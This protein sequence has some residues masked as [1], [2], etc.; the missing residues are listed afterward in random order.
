MVTLNEMSSLVNFR[1][2][3]KGNS[4]FAEWRNDTYCSLYS[5]YS[6][7]YHFPMYIFDAEASVVDELGNVTGK[8]VWLGNSDKY[9][10]TTTRHQNKCRPNTST[11]NNPMNNPMK[12]LTTEQMR[13]V[14]TAGGYTRYLIMRGEPLAA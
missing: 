12:Y 7:G 11:M 6:Y 8:G 13:E 9:S 2:P 10:V 5:V 14:F 3:F 4:V 1:M